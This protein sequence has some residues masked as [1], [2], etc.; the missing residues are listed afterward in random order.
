MIIFR[1]FIILALV[2]VTA[3]ASAQMTTDAKQAI[4]LDYETGQVLLEKNANQKM[5]TS[6]MSKVMT[7]YMMFD[8][9]KKGVLN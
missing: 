4:I 2:F 7:A 8:A 1:V 3:P 9:L 6:S 5:P